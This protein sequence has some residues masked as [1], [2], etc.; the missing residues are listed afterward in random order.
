MTIAGSRKSE[1]GSRKSEV[2]RRKAEGGRRKAE[3]GRRKAEG[4][5]GL[6]QPSETPRVADDV[7][8]PS[9]RAKRGSGPAPPVGHRKAASAVR[10]RTTRLRGCVAAIEFHARSAAA[11]A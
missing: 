1:V 2:G 3:G 6:P 10:H 5:G 4:A 7:R 9:P 11:L 8:P